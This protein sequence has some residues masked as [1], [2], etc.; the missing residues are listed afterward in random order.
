M[1][2][3]YT[4]EQLELIARIKTW[5]YSKDRQYFA[6]TGGAGTGK[7][8]VIK[9]CIEEL[10][11]NED[12]YIG[13]AFVGKA[14][15]NLLQHE[16]PATT[17]HSLIFKT[18]IELEKYEDD[19]GK[20][21]YKRSFKFV[22]REALQKKYKLIIVDEA[23]MVNDDLIAKILSFG[24]KVIFIGDNN[25]LPPIYGTSSVMQ[26]P[27]YTLTKIMRQSEDN[28]IVYLS[29]AVLRGEPLELGTY[30]DSK[31]IESYDI[32][33][34]IL[35]DFDQILCTTNNARDQ[36]NDTIRMDILRRISKDP[37]IGDKIICRQNDWTSEV[38]GIFLTNGLIGEITDIRRAGAS[39]GYYTISFQPDFMDRDF[40]DLKLDLKYMRA[41]Y[42][43]KKN[44]GISRYQKFEYGYAIT[45]HL[46][47]GSEYPRVLFADKYY[48]DRDYL[49]KL[50]Y[51]AIT[52]AKQSITIILDG[53]KRYY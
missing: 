46:S 27:D 33:D 50:R 48:R 9:A 25:Q 39:R 20:T 16:I 18:E 7:T 12:E 34:R 6:Y 53:A 11:L 31:I 49:K 15:L 2:I 5:F 29:Q 43:Q 3:I 52:R 51:T 13:C 10:H 47:Q 44:W 30:G 26:H 23:P 38:N 32:T 36:F 37:V 21:K 24:I 41:S 1:N 17:I 19:F 22:L 42:E 8:S 4:D 14:V 28:P 45:V 40:E 35:T